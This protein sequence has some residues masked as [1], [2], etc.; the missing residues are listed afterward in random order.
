VWKRKP[1]ATREAPVGESWDSQPEVRE[2]QTGPIGV[3]DRL[4]V[5]LRPS[6]VGGGKESEFK[7]DARRSKN[8]E[9]GGESE[10]SGKDS[11]AAEGVLR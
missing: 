7:R 4:V 3:A 9:I 10:N 11:E 5:L 2:D 1:D 6:N 8:Q